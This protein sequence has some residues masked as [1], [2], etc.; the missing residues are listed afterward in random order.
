MTHLWILGKDI[1]TSRA[2][3]SFSPHFLDKDLLNST[4]LVKHGWKHSLE[5]WQFNFRLSALGSNNI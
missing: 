1:F 2:K 4:N 3:Y 5:K